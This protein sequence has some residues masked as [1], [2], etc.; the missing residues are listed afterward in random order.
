M[1]GPFFTAAG[2]GYN[3]VINNGESIQLWPVYAANF[4]PYNLAQSFNTMFWVNVVEF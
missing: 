1:N 4:I 3:T 2:V